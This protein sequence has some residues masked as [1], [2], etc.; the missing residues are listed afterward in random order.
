MRWGSGQVVRVERKRGPVWYAQLPAALGPPGPEA[1][2]GRRGPSAARPPDGLLHEETGRGLAARAAARGAPAA[3][4]RAWS[5]RARRSPTPLR[6]TCATPSRT[7]AASPRRCAAT[8]RNQGAPAAGVRRMALEDITEQEIERWRAG[9]S[10]SLQREISN[11]TKNKQLVADA[12]DLRRAVKRLGLPANPVANVDRFRERSSGDIEVFSPEEVWALVRAAGVRA[13]RGDL[14]DRGV[15]RP[16]PRRAARAALARRRLRGLD[17]PR[18]R[19][20]R[21]RQADD[22]EVGQGARRCRWRPTSPR[23]WRGSATASGSSA[24]TTSCSPARPGCLDGDALGAATGTRSGRAG[25]RPLRFHDLR[26]TFGTRMIAQGR[27]PPG[28]GVDGPRRHPDDDEVPALRA[29]DG[30]RAARGAG[31]SDGQPRSHP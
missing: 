23:R 28:A 9:M 16:A 13:G 8:A 6:S 20:L 26:H 4:C 2:S 14:P 27:H 3:R 15:H 22:A 25:L 12:R 17:D 7:A 21:G 1:R 30:G 5:R 10:S 18:P 24:T 11:K 19:E 31:V 29:A